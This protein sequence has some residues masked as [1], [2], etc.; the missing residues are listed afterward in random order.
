MTKTI[1]ALVENAGLAAGF[2]D[3]VSTLGRYMEA[4]VEFDVVAASPLLSNKLAPFGAL[5]VIPGELKQ[6]RRDQEERAKALIPR[7]LDHAVMSVVDDVAWLPSMVRAEAPIADLIVVGP[8]ETWDVAW[9]RRHLAQT[10]LVTAGTPLL[11]LPAGRSVRKVDH[12]VVGWKPSPQATRALHDLTA[13]AAPGA[14][15]DVVN[16]ASGQP[17]LEQVNLKPVVTYLERQGFGVEA[18]VLEAK[19][20][21]AS[22]LAAFALDAGADLLTLGGYGHSRAREIFLGGVTRSVIEDCRIPTM[23]AH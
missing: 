9:L 12:A 4:H 6:M 18:H 8:A 20:R 21:T 22:R 17:D 16:V 7:D 1:L 10:L 19:G 3:A 15:I 23:L 11:L 5:Y 2:I 13:L 14:R